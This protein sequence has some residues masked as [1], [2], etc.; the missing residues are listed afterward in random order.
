LWT[1]PHALR[2]NGQRGR[3]PKQGRQKIRLAQQAAKAGWITEEVE[4]Y[5]R[6]EIKT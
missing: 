4:V 1:L 2:P 6:F 5:N 3:K